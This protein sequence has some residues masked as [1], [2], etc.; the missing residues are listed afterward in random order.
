MTRLTFRYCRY[1]AGR[2]SDD[3]DRQ[4]RRWL[5]CAGPKGRWRSNL[6]GKCL[7][8]GKAFDDSTVAPVVRQTLSRHPASPAADA[9]AHLRAGC[10]GHTNSPSATST[11]A[12]NVSGNAGPLTFPGLNSRMSCSPKKVPKLS[13]ALVWK[14]TP[15][16]TANLPRST[17]RAVG[18]ESAPSAADLP[19]CSS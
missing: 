2:R 5:S 7:R 1:F 12:P 15:T 9:V 10:T 4:I 8:D 19:P 18:P 17:R 3:D 13:C 6:I 16:Q 14:A 11:G